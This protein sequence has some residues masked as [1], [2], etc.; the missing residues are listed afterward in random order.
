MKGNFAKTHQGQ[1][2]LSPYPMRA[3][4]MVSQRELESYPHSAWTES[5][6]PPKE[7]ESCP[8]ATI[9]EFS[10]KF[11]AWSE[12]SIRWL[13]HTNSYNFN[14]FVV[15]RVGKSKILLSIS[16]FWKWIEAQNQKGAHQSVK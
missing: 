5:M 12:S 4:S 7:P 6:L 14:D 8:Y 9:R 10:M 2:E 1:P 16:D 11:P 15:R 13:I 3:E